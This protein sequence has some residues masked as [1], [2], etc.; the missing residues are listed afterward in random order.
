MSAA[1]IRGK[2]NGDDGKST[3]FAMLAM[4]PVLDQEA[5]VA[6]SAGP[7]RALE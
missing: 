6:A 2:S 1:T 7:S 4:L 3:Y 5:A